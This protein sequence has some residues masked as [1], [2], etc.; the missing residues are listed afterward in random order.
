MATIKKQ[1]HV[2]QAVFVSHPM[3]RG[4]SIQRLAVV[5]S[6]SA[7]SIY[8]C[9]LLD[10]VSPGGYYNFEMKAADE[11]KLSDREVRWVTSIRL[12]GLDIQ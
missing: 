10:Y 3:V 12:A 9:A 6:R 7:G 4:G 1:F 2:G 5:L 8:Q 11:D